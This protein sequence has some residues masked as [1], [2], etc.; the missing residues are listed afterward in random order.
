MVAEFWHDGKG[1]AKMEKRKL[2]R[3]FMPLERFPRA[4][5]RLTIGGGVSKGALA[6]EALQLWD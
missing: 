2:L 6:H 4:L 5:N 1:Y 3:S